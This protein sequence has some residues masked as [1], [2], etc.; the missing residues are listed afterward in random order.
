M[1]PLVFYCTL[2]DR[3]ADRDD[4]HRCDLGEVCAG[5]PSRLMLVNRQAPAG[6]ASRL[7]NPPTFRVSASG[8]MSGQRER[9][10]S[11]VGRIASENQG[12]STI[13]FSHLLGPARRAPPSEKG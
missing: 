1:T 6:S 3:E 5:I 9:G 4:C 2:L 10:R 12:K 13:R 8:G 11:T 7:Q